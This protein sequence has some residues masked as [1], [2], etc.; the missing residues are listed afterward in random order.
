MLRESILLTDF[1]R[2]HAPLAEIKK[3][4]LRRLEFP[5]DSFD[6]IWSRAS[7]LF[8]PKAENRETLLGFRRVLKS[9]GLLFLGM[10]EGEKILELK[11]G[12]GVKKFYAFYKLTHIVESCGFDII[13]CIRD[14]KPGVNWLCIYAG[15]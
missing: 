7:F 5:D 13:E 3:M 12:G 15:I 4:D 9:D 8:V 6:G 11:D 1:S 14:E 10:K 2:W